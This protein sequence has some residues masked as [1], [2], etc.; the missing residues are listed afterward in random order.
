MRVVVRT[1]VEDLCGPILRIGALGFLSMKD[2]GF[3]LRRVLPSRFFAPRAPW[4]GSSY[5]F[6]CRVASLLASMTA[7]RSAS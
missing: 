5:P 2:G 6:A 1:L 3:V 4:A 7:E